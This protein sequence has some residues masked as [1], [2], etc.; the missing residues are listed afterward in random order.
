MRTEKEIRD[1]IELLQKAKNQC[2]SPGKYEFYNT[3]YWA[4]KWVLGE[5]N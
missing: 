1:E 3:R 2:Q 5:E 4:L